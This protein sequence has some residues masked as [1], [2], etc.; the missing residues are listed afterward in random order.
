M[1]DMNKK[2]PSLRNRVTTGIRANLVARRCCP[3]LYSVI[4][5]IRIACSEYKN[6]PRVAIYC[7][8]HQKIRNNIEGE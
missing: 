5:N 4:K 7:T 2:T 1:I 3:H 6:V 8:H